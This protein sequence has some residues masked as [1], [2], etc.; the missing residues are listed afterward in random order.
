MAIASQDYRDGAATGAA[1]VADRAR[2][3]LS[4]GAPVDERVLAHL[5][6]GVR[7]IYGGRVDE[8]Q[9]DGRSFE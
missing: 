4:W 3:M 5:A 2:L 8:D 7:D 9:L 6:K 1:L